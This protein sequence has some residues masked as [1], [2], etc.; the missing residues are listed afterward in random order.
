[1]LRRLAERELAQHDILLKNR[2]EELFRN[3]P[4]QDLK[5]VVEVAQNFK[6]VSVG[7]NAAVYLPAT[8][9]VDEELGR[10]VRSGP[11]FVRPR[12]STF[13]V[14]DLWER[15]DYD[16]VIAS[17][18]YERWKRIRHPHISQ[19]GEVCLGTEEDTYFNLKAA[20]DLYSLVCVFEEIL[21]TYNPVSP[22]EHFNQK[23]PGSISPIEMPVMEAELF[24]HPQ[25]YYECVPKD[26]SD[27]D[28]VVLQVDGY[29]I[30]L[31]PRECERILRNGHRYIR[32]WLSQNL[33]AY[34][35]NLI[36]GSSTLEDENPDFYQLLNRIFMPGESW[37]ARAEA[38]GINISPAFNGSDAEMTAAYTPYS[39]EHAIAF[40]PDDLNQ[41]IQAED[42]DASEGETEEDSSQE[43]AATADPVT[44][45][46]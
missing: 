42:G 6:L 2:R 41:A 40:T 44:E 33:K 29:K 13:R 24:A 32:D 22:F 7:G 34:L 31:L 4:T 21:K 38:S 26:W 30:R 43:E 45:S 15:C 27:E 16:T 8:Y 1:M 23:F 14:V 35:P 9:W 36:T 20:G 17:P 39:T 25:I 10:A 11:Y 3:W 46:F 19:G 18:L 37:T 28:L 5:R 12:N